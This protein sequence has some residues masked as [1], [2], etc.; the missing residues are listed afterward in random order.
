MAEFAMHRNVDILVKDLGIVDAETGAPPASGEE[1]HV[2]KLQ[3]Q[4]AQ[5]IADDVRRIRKS[6]S[7]GRRSNGP[8]IRRLLE[9]W[10]KNIEDFTLAVIARESGHNEKPNS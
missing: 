2:V 4:A 9:N 3:L 6:A 5:I 7:F 10:V 8:I 1:L